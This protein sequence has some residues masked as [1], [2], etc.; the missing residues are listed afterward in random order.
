MAIKEYDTSGLLS[1][2]PAEALPDIPPVIETME[3]IEGQL[4][5]AGLGHVVDFN[6]VYRNLTGA[7]YEGI[8]TEGA[9]EQPETVRRTVGIFAQLYFDPL[10]A[11][12]EGRKEDIPLAWQRLFY[13][14]GVQAT[15]SGIKFLM[16]M[17][18]HINYD[19]PQALRTSNVNQDYYRDYRVV[20]GKFI[21]ATANRLSSTYIPVE[22]IGR[23]VLVK[24]ACQTIAYWRERAW[25]AGTA[26]Q[27]HNDNEKV[28]NRIIHNLDRASD[29]KGWSI[30]HLGSMAMSALTRPVFSF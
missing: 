11:Y 7:V 5:T 13:D 19:L 30:Q 16:G 10:R 25:R 27:K 29:R 4:A 21:D 23:D 26:L 3:A 6:Y 12:A 1:C 28:T 15:Q 8:Q 24:G 20:I 18:A 9:F 2:L 22:G 14:P 17:N